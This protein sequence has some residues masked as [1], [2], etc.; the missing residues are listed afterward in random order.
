VGVNIV[1]QG[2]IVTDSLI[3]Y[4]KRHPALD[5]QCSK[6][7]QRAFLTTDSTVDFDRQAAIFYGEPVQSVQLTL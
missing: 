1:S 5:Q 3:D 7:G 4:L 6:H 2:E